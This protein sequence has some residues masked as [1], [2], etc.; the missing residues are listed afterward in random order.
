MHNKNQLH[1]MTLHTLA[2]ASLSMVS[3]FETIIT[4]IIYL[5]CHH[6][7]PPVSCR[8]QRLC[9]KKKGPSVDSSA[10]SAQTLTVFSQFW[11]C[12]VTQ[13]IATYQVVETTAVAPR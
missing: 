9:E 4:L 5:L 11:N 8:N 3:W 1:A 13:G 6:H 2:A 7:V 10:H 12:D